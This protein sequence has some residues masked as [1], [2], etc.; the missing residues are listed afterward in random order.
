MADAPVRYQASTCEGS[1]LSRCGRG[2][3]TAPIWRSPASGC[4]RCDGR[5]RGAPWRRSGSAR[6]RQHGECHAVARL[7]S[8]VGA[9]RRP[10]AGVGRGGRLGA[11]G[12]SRQ[13]GRLYLRVWSEGPGHVCGR[14][15][16]CRPNARPPRR[17]PR[18]RNGHRRPRALPPLVSRL[19]VPLVPAGRRRARRGVHGRY[20]AWWWY[21]AALATLGS[22]AGCVSIHA[23]AARGGEAFLRKRF[24]AG[25]VNARDACHPALRANGDPRSVDILRRRA[26]S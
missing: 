21:Y 12:E 5:P 26:S 17:H 14:G 4:R 7:A 25:H 11:L 13:G 3:A 1:A 2:G 16:Q 19:V 10:T 23:L 9:P 22:V 18:L 8:A 6:A 15:G 24:K 20:P